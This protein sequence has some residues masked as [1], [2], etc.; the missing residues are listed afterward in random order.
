MFASLTSA[1]R[2]LFVFSL[3]LSAL[4]SAGGCGLV[5]PETP[6]DVAIVNSPKLKIRSSTAMVALDLAEVKRGD[7]LDVLEQAQVKT[8]TRIDEWY[9]VRTKDK[10][11]TIGWVKARE[12]ITKAVVDKVE[13]LYE[14]SK[15]IPS[16]A[17][18]RLK[19]QARLRIE[20]GGDVAILLS[21]HTAVDIVGKARTTF[22]PAKQQSAEDSDETTEEP[23]ARTVLWYQVRLPDSEVL[24]AGWIGAQ[25][26]QLDVP[27]EILHLEGEGRR[28]TGWVV[29]DQTK[30]K[31]GE[32]KNNYI[33]LMKSLETEGPIDFTRVWLLIYSPTEG[34]Y[35]GPFIESGLRG[36]L[37]V[38][39]GIQSGPKGFTIHELD[40]D[41]KSVPIE[42]SAVRSDAS[43]LTVKRLS[44]RIEVKRVPKKKKG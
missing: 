25:Q 9:K 20:P 39:P 13:E 38:T 7:R 2:R 33:G 16:Q 15:E 5:S 4:L 32:L 42:Y 3:S 26:I 41:G 43:H 1:K 19:V 21:K 28:F 10:N 40:A 17:Q 27:D 36:V 12:L 31:K 34:R 37:P 22:K 30:S 8:P 11:E 14:K 18:G 35:T 29:F 23:E 6:I 24:R 44:P